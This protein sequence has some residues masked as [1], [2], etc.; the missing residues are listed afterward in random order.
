[1]KYL[2][3]LESF[4]RSKTYIK[5]YED[6]NKYNKIKYL[7]SIAYDKAI[8]HFINLHEKITEEHIHEFINQYMI[9]NYGVDLPHS[10]EMYDYVKH[11]LHNKLLNNK[12]ISESVENDELRIGYYVKRKDILSDDI[13]IITQPAKPTPDRYKSYL[14]WYIENIKDLG[15]NYMTSDELTLFAKDKEEL[16]AK[17]AA[18]KYNIL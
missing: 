12:K 14:G 5:L 8:R 11:L 1:M 9:N 2:I 4:T 13:Y 17:L 10:K 7:F 16:E 3:K 15:W 6:L 18:K